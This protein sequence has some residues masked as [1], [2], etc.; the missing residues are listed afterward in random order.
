MQIKK[1]TH[2]DKIFYL[3]INQ[4]ILLAKNKHPINLINSNE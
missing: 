3:K 1:Y 2:R 4:Q